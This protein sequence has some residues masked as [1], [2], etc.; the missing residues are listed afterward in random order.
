MARRARMH[1]L[2]NEL[3]AGSFLSYDGNP[4]DALIF[5]RSKVLEANNCNSSFSGLA[6]KFGAGE[7]EGV[8]GFLIFIFSFFLFSFF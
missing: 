6:G 5:Y 3:A 1:V 4:V 8:F 2:L 7:G